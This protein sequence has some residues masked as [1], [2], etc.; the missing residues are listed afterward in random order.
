M[1]I[2]RDANRYLHDLPKEDA[3]GYYGLI[4]LAR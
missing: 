2:L 3:K 4:K 1:L